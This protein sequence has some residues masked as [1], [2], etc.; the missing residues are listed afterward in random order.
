LSW[1]F[2]MSMLQFGLLREAAITVPAL[3][4]G[5]IQP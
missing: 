1:W 5:L 2:N 4:P 3:T